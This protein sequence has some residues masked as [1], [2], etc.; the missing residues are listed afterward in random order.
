[1]SIGPDAIR[2]GKKRLYIHIHDH[3]QMQ[4]QNRELPFKPTNP[5]LIRFQAYQKPPP[6]IAKRLKFVDFAAQHSGRG[7]AL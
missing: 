3:L 4:D 5:Q 1:M 7:S 2:K 6:D